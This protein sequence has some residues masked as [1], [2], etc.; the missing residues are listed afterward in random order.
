MSYGRGVN[1]WRRVSLSPGSAR[2]LLHG[3]HSS[4]AAAGTLRTASPIALGA[5]LPFESEKLISLVMTR[6]ILLAKANTPRGC[7]ESGESVQR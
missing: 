5:G 4:S 6:E 3:T 1:E 2:R 7:L